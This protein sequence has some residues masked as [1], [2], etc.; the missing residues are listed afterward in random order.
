[1]NIHG[2]EQCL[3]VTIEKNKNRTE[4]K[5]MSMQVFFNMYLADKNHKTTIHTY[6]LYIYRYIYLYI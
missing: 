1:M 4:L 6:F 2:Y 5:T 3:H